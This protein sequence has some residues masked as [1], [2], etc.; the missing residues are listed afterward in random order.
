VSPEFAAVLDRSIKTNTAERFSSAQTMQAALANLSMATAPTEVS[1]APKPPTDTFPKTVDT[2]PK[3]DYIHQTQHPPAVATVSST[4]T[5]ES[6][7]PSYPN[8]ISQTNSKQPDSLAIP[9]VITACIIG[10]SILAGA[11]AIVSNLPQSTEFP[12][13]S[14]DS[15]LVETPVETPASEE[16]TDLPPEL[17][18][19]PEIPDVLDLT[20]IVEPDAATP[21]WEFMGTASSGESI[22][23]NVSS[24]FPG[25]EFIEFE[26]R[27]GDEYIFASADCFENRWYAEGYGWYPPQSSATQNMLDYVCQ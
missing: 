10:V 3:T 25:E 19:E 22:A 26:Y 23:V 4:A 14:S 6:A 24:I 9:A 13:T 8:N 7:T 15:S 18:V 1:F 20:P 5:T 2:L 17:D 21:V 27:I 12:V 11:F 16:F